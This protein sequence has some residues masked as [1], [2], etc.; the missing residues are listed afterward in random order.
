MAVF[1]EATAAQQKRQLR[2]ELRTLRKSLTPAQ[3]R[4]ASL[5]LIRQL[6][7][8]PNYRSVRHIALYWANDGEIDVT[9]LM[10]RLLADRKKVYLPV[11]HPF[12][13]RLRF[14]L[15]R[16]RMAMKPNRFGI[17]E[18]RG[19]PALSPWCL[20]WVLLP[21]VGFDDMGGRLGM[22]GGFYDR[23]FA[24]EGRWP[25][26]PARIGVA[27]ECQRVGQVPLEP[28]DIPLAAVATDQSIYWSVS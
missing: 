23:T 14:R 7:S 5:G 9:P 6:T 1:L 2:R 3:Q 11:L 12:Q 25:R 28:W 21:L 10:I 27:H 4:Q 24:H 19:G 16:P 20:D 22:G 8:L 17:P 13:P 26:Q 18:P 15:W